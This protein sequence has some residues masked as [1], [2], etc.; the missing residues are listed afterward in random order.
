MM[1]T[2]IEVDVVE[3]DGHLTVLKTDH[4]K[5]RLGAWSLIDGKWVEADTIAFFEGCV[6]S[7]PVPKEPPLPAW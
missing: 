1:K 6:V 4:D 2:G 7:N 3:F 5:K